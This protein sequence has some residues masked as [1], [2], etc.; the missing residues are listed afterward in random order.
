MAFNIGEA[1][2]GLARGYLTMRQTQSANTEAV[3]QQ[4]LQLLL[5]LQDKAQQD[6][7]YQLRLQ[8]FGLEKANAERTEAWRLKEMENTNAQ[9]LLDRIAK[10]QSERAAQRQ[11][12]QGIASVV[13]GVQPTIP[14]AFVSP[15][16]AWAR[17]AAGQRG[18]I[19]AGA[20]QIPQASP[21]P[22]AS[23][24]TAQASLAQVLEAA[25]QHP[26][27]LEVSYGPQ[28]PSVKRITTT[29]SQ[30]SQIDLRA[31]QEALAL[32]KT[33]T[34]QWTTL[35]TQVA[36]QIAQTTAPAEIT[37]A[38]TA[39]ST[40]GT[41]LEIL[42]QD[43]EAHPEDIR[44]R[45]AVLSTRA[46]L[47]AATAK[48]TDWMRTTGRPA[49][50][51][52]RR[53]NARIARD[54]LA[55]TIRY[56]SGMLAQGQQEIDLE[57]KRLEASGNEQDKLMAAA[58]G[59]ASDELYKALSAEANIG[60]P[61]DVEGIVC[62]SLAGQGLNPDDP[63]L[64]TYLYR[65]LTPGGGTVTPGGAPELPFGGLPPGVEVPRQ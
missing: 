19:P 12:T 60:R 26:N 39:A 53:E 25:A 13:S 28:G 7:D 15:E 36:A 40:A 32:A 20:A 33:D 14:T 24:P 2:L 41:Q 42:Q 59:A 58:V 49:D 54:Q 8:Q 30:Q 34:E 6:R 4:R 3:R 47:N 23:V 64:Q 38:F 52:I 1:L 48:L 10:D 46:N 55:E 5:A 65:L 57:A 27:E 11:L 44:L 31:A 56:H 37:Q 62:R 50:I 17:A 16:E 63:D 18:V 51:E 61:V 22:A 29:P 45:H 35:K 21:V 9:A 43:L